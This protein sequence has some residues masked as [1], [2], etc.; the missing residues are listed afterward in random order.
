M[1]A[2]VVR[3]A[4]P[5]QWKDFE[6]A[7]PDGVHRA[8]SAG[9]WTVLQL[10]G[11]PSR[12]SG[13]RAGRVL[14]RADLILICTQLA[15]LLRAGL[16]VAEAAQALRANEVLP[17]KAA[18]FDQ[19]LE[20]L[21]TGQS[22]AGALRI[23]PGVPPLLV[24]MVGAAEHSAELPTA[25]EGYAGYARQVE[26]LSMRMRA[27]AVYPAFLMAVGSA[28]VMFMLLF[29]VPRFAGIFDSIRTEL[30]WAARWMLAWGQFAGLHRGP[31]GIGLLAFTAGVALVLGRV[32]LRDRM[33]ARLGRMSVIRRL[34]EPFD[35][36]RL[37]RAVGMLLLGGMSIVR[38]LEAAREVV[39]RSMLAA[40]DR[41]ILDV[42]RGMTTSAAL[43][44]YGLA[45]PV[46]SSL[47]VAGERSGNLGAMFDAAADF[48]ERE[49][50][51]AID[52]VSRVAEPALMTVIGLV[53]G[54]IVVLMYL[55]IFE[56]A[57]SLQ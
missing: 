10:E 25:L 56:L 52:R 47:F 23:A 29:V 39:P 51:H 8:A 24:A 57:S 13:V 1:R 36:A 14:K 9:G 49:A 41:A 15:V 2:L 4:E 31:I 16:A 5:P 30:P 40:L 28:V 44:A 27:A 3:D 46:P 19:V 34:R 26:A 48:L 18:F 53:V 33:L 11:G 45:A 38:A 42:R 21:R 17:H 7:T 22:L 54:V 43:S 50:S 6:M 20:Q 12:A 37:Y 55:P 32:D 35:L